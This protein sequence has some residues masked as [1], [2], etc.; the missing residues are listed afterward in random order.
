MTDR[1]PNYSVQNQTQNPELWIDTCPSPWS[2]PCAK[3]LVAV[4]YS[5]F[6]DLDH[7][8]KL[9]R[10]RA[11]IWLSDIIS[12]DEMSLN[13]ICG[14]LGLNPIYVTSLM[15]DTSRIRTL[16]NSKL[17]DLPKRA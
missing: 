5:A 3:L 9:T 4:L 6:Y 11:E 15:Y 16:L 1:Y 17:G 12:T 10:T 13:W 7:K 14:H 8:H 2:D